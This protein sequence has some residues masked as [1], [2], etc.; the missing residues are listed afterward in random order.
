M[1]KS[2][3]TLQVSTLLIDS[4]SPGD[5]AEWT[6][7]SFNE[8]SRL[9]M[10][11]MHLLVKPLEERFKARGSFRHRTKKRGKAPP[12][13]SGGCVTNLNVASKSLVTGLIRAWLRTRYYSIV[14]YLGPAW[15]LSNRRRRELLR[16]CEVILAASL[17][18]D[19]IERALDQASSTHNIAYRGAE[20]MPSTTDDL[21]E[22]SVRWP[23]SVDAQLGELQRGFREIA[24]RLPPIVYNA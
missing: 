4:S 2:D 20:S 6:S 12:I 24:N 17:E 7:A 3:L 10:Q 14:N 21:F 22:M 19:D 11:L 18:F 23:Q 1:S 13:E 5:P 8:P 9:E 15:K 16:F